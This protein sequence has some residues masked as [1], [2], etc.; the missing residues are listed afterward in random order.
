MGAGMGRLLRLSAVGGSLSP[1]VVALAAAALEARAQRLQGAVAG[2]DTDSGA[3][4]RG[5]PDGPLLAEGRDLSDDDDDDDD[6]CFIDVGNGASS[7]EHRPDAPS[8]GRRRQDGEEDDVERDDEEAAVGDEDEDEDEV[9]ELMAT[10][11]AG[12]VARA[13]FVTKRSSSSNPAPVVDVTAEENTRR[14]TM[15]APAPVLRSAAPTGALGVGET[16][17]EMPSATVAA[18]GAVAVAAVP[19][20]ATHLTQAMRA[21]AVQVLAQSQSQAATNATLAT[22]PA[23]HTSVVEYESDGTQHD[24]DDEEDEGDADERVDGDEDGGN[25]GEWV[26]DRDEDGDDDARLETSWRH[27]LWRRQLSQGCILRPLRA[28]ARRRPTPR[29]RL[30]RLPGFRALQLRDERRSLHV[31]AG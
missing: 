26:Q 13:L 15:R 8:P 27:S 4:L 20:A 14:D 12:G 19:V 10:A 22:V 1:H 31:R 18:P 29:T 7:D 16:P 5:Q 25:G 23:G 9:E 30:R 6:D 11:A 17:V 24:G 28:P 3:R 21:A 2:A